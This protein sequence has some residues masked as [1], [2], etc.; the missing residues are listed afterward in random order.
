MHFRKSQVSLENKKIGNK[1]TK[2]K[3]KHPNSSISLQNFTFQTPWIL[4]FNR[5]D[6][7]IKENGV[8]IQLTV[9]PYGK[10]HS[11]AKFTSKITNYY[12]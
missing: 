2:N 5:K 8:C 7:W 6:C 11:Y 1:Q 3:T 9:H 12:G 4:D 10:A